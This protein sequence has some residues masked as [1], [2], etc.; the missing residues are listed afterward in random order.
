MNDMFDAKPVRKWDFEKHEYAPIEL[1]EDWIVPMLVP[2]DELDNL[3][4]CANCGKKVPYGE[5][6]T[7]KQYHNMTGLGFGVCDDCYKNEQKLEREYER[8]H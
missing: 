4:N 6:M 7:S 2:V 3:V 8:I 5:T 1:P